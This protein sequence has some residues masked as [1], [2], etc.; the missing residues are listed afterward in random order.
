RFVGIGRFQGFES[1]FFDHIDGAHADQ[2]L[3][4]DQKHET[5]ALSLVVGGHRGIRSDIDRV[6]SQRTRSRNCNV[7]GGRKFREYSN[8]SDLPVRR[9]WNVP[10]AEKTSLTF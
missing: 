8:F 5:L 3:V 7:S 9:I 1:R 4:I 6:T 2:R 10:Y